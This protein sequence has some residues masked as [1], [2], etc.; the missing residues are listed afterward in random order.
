VEVIGVQLSV[1]TVTMI[2]AP[3][4]E[5]LFQLLSLIFNQTLKLILGVRKTKLVVLLLVPVRT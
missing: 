3:S 1:T 4:I 2:L 5:S